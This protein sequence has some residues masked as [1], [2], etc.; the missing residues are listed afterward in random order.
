VVLVTRL[1][2]QLREALA[3]VAR[4]DVDQPEHARAFAQWMSLGQRGETDILAA[5]G[6]AAQ[7]VSPS[8]PPCST[9]RATATRDFKTLSST[10]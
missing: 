5:L 3:T 8:T 1:L 10:R 2:N 4:D 9:M 7:R 6:D